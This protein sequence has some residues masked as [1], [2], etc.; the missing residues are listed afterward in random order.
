MDVN[1]DPIKSAIPS[2]KA[3]LYIR[4]RDEFYLDLEIFLIEIE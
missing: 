3:T 2:K 1:T 4:N